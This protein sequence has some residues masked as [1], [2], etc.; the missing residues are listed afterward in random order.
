MSI[1][2]FNINYLT[3]PLE[4]WN[5]EEKICFLMGD[6]NI[7]VMKMASENDNCQ[8]YIQYCEFLSFFS[9]NTSTHKD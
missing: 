3:P 5:R 9:T 4:K 6:F 1:T 8:F 7:N 2:D